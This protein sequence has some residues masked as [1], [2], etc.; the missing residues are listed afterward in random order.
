MIFF[1]SAG[2]SL[3]AQL[4]GFRFIKLSAVDQKAVVKTP[5]GKLLLVG[6]GDDVGDAKIARI[7]ENAVVLERPNGVRMGFRGQ[8]T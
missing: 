1:L 4:E 8:F 2:L 3:A 5:E 7:A 6:V